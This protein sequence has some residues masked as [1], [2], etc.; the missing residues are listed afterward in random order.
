LKATNIDIA[1]GKYPLGQTPFFKRKTSN[2]L[3]IVKLAQQNNHNIA[4][5]KSSHQ[6]SRR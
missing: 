4:A 5:T 6:L 1:I 2:F 3:K